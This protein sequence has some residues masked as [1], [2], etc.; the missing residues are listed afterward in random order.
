M[1]KRN[2]IYQSSEALKAS[3][4]HDLRKTSADLNLNI[5]E[6]YEAF[7]FLN[8]VRID[9]LF[10]IERVLEPLKKLIVMVTHNQYLY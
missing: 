8:L 4:A 3:I 1:G 6:V 9:P 10:V 7:A 5:D 2:C